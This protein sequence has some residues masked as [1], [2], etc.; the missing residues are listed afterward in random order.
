VGSVIFGQALYYGSRSVAFYGCCV[1]L[2]IHLFVLIY[3]EPRLKRLFGAEY[4][5]YR[6]KVPRWVLRIR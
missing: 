4:G 1:V 3:E 6:A 2:A 5:E